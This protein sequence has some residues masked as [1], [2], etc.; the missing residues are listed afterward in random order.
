MLTKYKDIKQIINI[1]AQSP[2][3]NDDDFRKYKGLV[4][5]MC[6]LSEKYME[7]K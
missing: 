5:R 6:E 3:L 2:E 4:I 1:L 7:G